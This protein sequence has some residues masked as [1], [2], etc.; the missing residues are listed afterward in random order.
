M[1]KDESTNDVQSLNPNARRELLNNEFLTGVQKL[2]PEFRKALILD[3]LL[4]SRPEAVV[5]I[6]SKDLSELLRSQ[7]TEIAYSLFALEVHKTLIATACVLVKQRETNERM[8]EHY[9]HLNE[10]S[11]EQKAEKDYSINVKIPP[12]NA[13]GTCSLDCKLMRLFLVR[14]VSHYKCECSFGLSEPTE[15]SI[16]KDVF[17]YCLSKP[18]NS[19]CPRFEKE[20]NHNA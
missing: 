5:A 7:P 13:N 18:A 15:F 8:L 16:S 1:I 17:S 2:K 10:I 6:K 4:R 9:L 19:D 12:L 20:E 14:Y 11:E 3:M